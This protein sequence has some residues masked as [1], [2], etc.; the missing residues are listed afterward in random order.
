[1]LN[2]LTVEADE[3]VFFNFTDSS[4]VDD[5]TITVTVEMMDTVTTPEIY[6]MVCP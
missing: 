5:T 4:F 3:F 1:V 2:Q 6:Y